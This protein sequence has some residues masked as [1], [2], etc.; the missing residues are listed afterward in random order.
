MVFPIDCPGDPP[1]ALLPGMPIA[2]M[3]ID[4]PGWGTPAS[5]VPG[6]RL[7]AMPSDCP[8]GV[9]HT[10]KVTRNSDRGYP[11]RA[12]PIDGITIDCPGVFPQPPL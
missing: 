1:A 12:M 11:Y 10:A 9:P 7:D 8:D 2:C 4:C 6:M 5:L 3:P